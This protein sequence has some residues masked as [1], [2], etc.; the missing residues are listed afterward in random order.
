[1]GAGRPCADTSATR[2]LETPDGG[3]LLVAVAADGAGSALRG[4]EG[5]R[6]ACERVLEKAAA[7]VRVN[8]DLGEFA[9]VDAEVWVG[10]V[11]ERILEGATDAGEDHREYA[12]TLLVALVDHRR[13]VLFQV[14]DGAIVH[15]DSRGRYRPALWPQNGH[16]ANS[17]WFVTDDHVTDVVRVKTLYRVHELALLTD[18]LQSLA[19]RFVSREAHGPFFS[20]MFRRLRRED[21]DACG[22]LTRELERFLDSDSVNARTDDDKTLV[23]ATRLGTGGRE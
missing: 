3:G 15:R 12:T 6:L 18:G 19:L 5:A 23:L 22:D 17:T 2:V 11:R 21:Q 4:D 10:D 14:G 16:Y 1:V 20:P 8:G 9:T 7:W 13:A